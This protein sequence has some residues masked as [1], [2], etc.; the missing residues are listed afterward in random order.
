MDSNNLIPKIDLQQQTGK[1]VDSQAAA[2]RV[3]CEE[4]GFF[5]ITGHDISTTV[6][7][8]CRDAAIDFFDR[9]ISEKKRVQQ[10]TPG[11]PYGYSPM[12]QETLALS[13]IHI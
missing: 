4:T 6:M 7:E 10:L 1:S 3:A 12:A 5:V 8:A 2:I 13:L 9:P 11:S